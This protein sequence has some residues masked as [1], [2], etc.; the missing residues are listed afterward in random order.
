[1]GPLFCVIDNPLALRY[2]AHLGRHTFALG[3]DASPTQVVNALKQ[4]YTT[5][6]ITCSVYRL[7]AW[8]NHWQFGIS[9]AAELAAQLKL[10]PQWCSD[11][12]FNVSN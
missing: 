6:P 5:N 4:D 10:I 12:R 3:P 1:M 9:P 8:R 7:A 2:F 11:P